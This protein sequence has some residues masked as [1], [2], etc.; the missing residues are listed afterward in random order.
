M[1]MKIQSCVC[2]FLFMIL[3]PPRSTR[4]DTLFPYTTLFRSNGNQHQYAG[5]QCQFATG[6]APDR[7][8]GCQRIATETVAE[9]RAVAQRQP[10]HAEYQQDLQP[11]QQLIGGGPALRPATKDKQRIGQAGGDDQRSEGGRVGEEGGST[12]R[13][14]GA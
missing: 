7:P 6:G 3:R 13:S 5:R 8:Q 4:T 14:R 2:F 12:G 9:S 1:F 10:D 11:Q